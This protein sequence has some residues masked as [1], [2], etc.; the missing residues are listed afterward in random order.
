MVFINLSYAKLSTELRDGTVVSADL[1]TIDPATGKIKP[2]TTLD[3]AGASIENVQSVTSASGKW[4]INNEGII[5]AT[6]LRAERLCLGS[7][8]VTESE[9]KNLL[10]HAGT[11]AV[12]FVGNTGS[13]TGGGGNT[14]STS[15]IVEAPSTEP[16]T[17]TIPEIP[18]EEPPV[19]EAPATPPPP[20]LPV[21]PLPAD[22]NPPTP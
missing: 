22:D 8:C 13:S 11:A 21:A 16:A 1:W 14:S 3:L 2:Y 18:Q 5:I 12:G 6:E 7:T 9:L 4:S 17:T 20:E 15:P 10:E 19:V